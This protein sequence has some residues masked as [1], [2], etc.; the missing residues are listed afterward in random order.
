MTEEPVGGIE[1][2]R[3]DCVQPLDPHSFCFLER[4]FVSACLEDGEFH[5]ILQD[6]IWRREVCIQD[7]AALDFCVGIGDGAFVIVDPKAKV[8]LAFA[9]VLQIAFG[10]SQA[11][12]QHLG[13]TVC[14]SV[15]WDDE[16]MGFVGVMG[17]D[18]R[19]KGKVVANTAFDGFAF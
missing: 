3:V 15:L 18:F 6:M 7:A 5:I 1:S 16:G 10:A 11:V 8:R 4:V 9:Y 2:T 14:G 12:D 13:V 19:L 17:G